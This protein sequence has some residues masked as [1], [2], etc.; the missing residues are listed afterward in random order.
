MPVPDERVAPPEP[1]GRA[2]SPSAA[3]SVVEEE[4]P[5]QAYAA[6]EASSPRCIAQRMGSTPSRATNQSSVTS[7]TRLRRTRFAPI[8]V[9]QRPG[10]RHP[11]GRRAGAMRRLTTDTAGSGSSW[12]SSE[13]TT[14]RSRVFSPSLTSVSGLG[15]AWPRGGRLLLER[16]R[17]D[18]P[19][20]D[21]YVEP[22]WSYASQHPGRAAEHVATGRVV[23]VGSVNMD[24]AVRPA[25]PKPGET[26]RGGRSMQRRRRQPGR[27]RGP[28]RWRGDRDTSTSRTPTDIARSRPGS[29]RDGSTTR[30]RRLDDHPTWVALITID[31]DGEHDHRRGGRQRRRDSQRRGPRRPGHR[32][33]RPRP[34]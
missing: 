30:I 12:R 25:L 16:G 22:Q 7:A 1:D 2:P 21:A 9:W 4:E 13:T 24:V 28:R 6:L 23:V 5:T 26:L 14:P 3:S 17:P 31:A 34:A 15:T 32:G 29:R 27:R 8:R 18:R 11:A 19:A 20:A 10:H 33:R